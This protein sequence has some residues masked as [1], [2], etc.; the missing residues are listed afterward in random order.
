MIAKTMRLSPAQVSKIRTAAAVH[1][2]GKV[3]TPSEILLK[4]GSLTDE[5]FA[6]MKQHPVTGARMVERLGDSEITDIVRHHHERMDGRGYPD[7]LRGDEIPIGARVVAVADTFDAITSARPYRHGRNHAEAIEILKRASGNQLDPEVVD[8]FLAYYSGKRALTLWMSLSNALQRIVGGFGNWVQQAQA[9]GFAAGTASLGAAVTMTAVLG[10][11]M[12]A[13]AH[14]RHHQREAGEA[15]VAA[16]FEPENG[17]VTWV[18]T[19]RGDYEDDSADVSTAD[20]PWADL[21]TGDAGEPSTTPGEEGS[22]P[23]RGG[24]DVDPS[25]GDAAVTQQDPFTTVTTEPAADPSDAEPAA[26]DPTDEPTAEPDD[27]DTAAAP[28]EH[29]HAH[30]KKPKKSKTK[31]ANHAGANSHRG[32]VSKNHRHSDR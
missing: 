6:V 19:D 17:A 2:V 26:E 3:E 13:V 9:G 11:V 28:P 12:P 1:D 18:P 22:D 20:N 25:A 29:G 7:A 10:G 32:G 14:G 27:P 23:Q 15:S 5:E 16:A 31:N 30:A 24:R 8:A 4:P 21:A